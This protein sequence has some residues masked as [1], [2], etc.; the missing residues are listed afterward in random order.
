MTD[1][2]ATVTLQYPITLTLKGAQGER[3]ETIAELQFAR[4]KAK[5]LRAM[6]KE[7]G[8]V[9]KL[10]ALISA[11][12]GQPMRVIEA[13]DGADMTACGRVLADFLGTSPPTGP[14]S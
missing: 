10:M 2:L 3:E 12:S 11:L 13:M 4:P 9:G 14:T 6:D 7:A 1:T 5:H 8:E